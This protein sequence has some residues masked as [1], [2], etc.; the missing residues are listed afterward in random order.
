MCHKGW[1]GPGVPHHV[2]FTPCKARS[3]P[4]TQCQAHSSP[5]RKMAQAGS[6]PLAA[7][8]GN[9]VPNKMLH[10]LVKRNASVETVDNKTSMDITMA[11]PSP[12]TLTTGTSTAHLNSIETTPEDTSR[13]DVGEPA[14]SGGA[15]DGAASSAPTT[16]AS[17]T[18]R[19]VASS[20]PT[21]LTPPGPMSLFTGQT[22]STTA[23]GRPSLSTALIQVPSNSSSPRAAVLATLAT[24][25]Q[26]V[27]TRANTSSPMSTPSPSEYMT[28]DTTASPTPPTHPQ[29]QVPTR[30]V[31]VDQPMVNTTDRSTPPSNTTLEPTTTH[32]VALVSPVVVTT[33][34]PQAKESTTSTVPAPHISPVPKVEAT[35]LTTQPSPT[36]STPRATGPRTP[37]APEQVETKAPPGTDSTAPTPRSS[38]DPKMP[39]TDSCQPSTQGQY[40]VVTTEPLTQAVV[41]KTF[42]LVVL[43]LGVALFITV[44][45][46][47][48][49]QAYESYKKKD[50]TQVDYLINGMYADSEM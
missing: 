9:F 45:V 40:L 19:S 50:Y 46:L 39:A 44:L 35:S 6:M 43:L 7:A 25:A 26:T 10:G 36:P 13:T 11:A 4:T 29:A 8:S 14:T 48:A 21:T 41:D 1:H 16:A 30:Q 15:A 32:S 49:L 27:V 3:R 38:G 5:K 17:S 33:P 37:Q 12:V 31:S 2:V 34:K 28:G 24:R 22:P 23:A 42:L 20:A 47:F 18:S